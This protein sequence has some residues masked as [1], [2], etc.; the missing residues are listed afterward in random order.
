MIKLQNPN[1]W[2]LATNMVYFVW[3]RR[4]FHHIVALF[5]TYKMENYFLAKYW[6]SNR[7]RKLGKRDAA[8]PECWWGHVST[9]FAECFC[10]LCCVLVFVECFLVFCGV[11]FLCQVYYILALNIGYLSRALGHEQSAKWN[12]FVKQSS[13]HIYVIFCSYRTQHEFTPSSEVFLI[14]VFGV[15]CFFFSMR[16]YS[17]ELTISTLYFWLC[18]S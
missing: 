10:H 7:M 14:S 1:M 3:K 16:C 17:L 12:F 2:E 18:P 8:S 6:Y 4:Y 9:T 15:I 5:G 11:L 13:L